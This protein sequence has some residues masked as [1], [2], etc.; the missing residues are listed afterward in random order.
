[1]CQETKQKYESL[2]V[3]SDGD[4][5]I[6]FH[7]GHIATRPE[8]VVRLVNDFMVAAGTGS[9]IIDIVKTLLLLDADTPQGDTHILLRIRRANLGAIV[10]PP[11]ELDNLPKQPAFLTPVELAVTGEPTVYRLGV[12]DFEKPES[13]DVIDIQR[14]AGVADDESTPELLD[15]EGSGYVAEPPWDGGDAA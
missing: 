12:P 1:M 2:E 8:D 9:D 13:L 14:E 5:V 3:D 6:N 10:V 7:Q 15:P 4:V 11:T